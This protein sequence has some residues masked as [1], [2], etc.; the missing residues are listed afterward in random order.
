MTEKI[1]KLIFTLWE[2]PQN[3]LGQILVWC[4]GAKK[5]G[6]WI[7]AGVYLSDSFSGGISLGRFIILRKYDVTTVKHEYGHS[8]QSRMLGPLYLLIVGLPSILHA[9]TWDNSKGSY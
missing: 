8:L 4:Y 1:A 6:D 7:D 3:I 9:S 2:L 5:M